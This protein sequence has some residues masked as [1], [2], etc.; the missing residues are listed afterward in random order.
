VQAQNLRIESS[1]LGKLLDTSMDDLGL[2]IKE[3]IFYHL[4][5]RGI[6]FKRGG[7]YTLKQISYELNDIM[8]EA[9]GELVMKNLLKLNSSC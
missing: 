6:S 8:G 1:L 4:E 9:G 3:I 5:L 2:R 7:E